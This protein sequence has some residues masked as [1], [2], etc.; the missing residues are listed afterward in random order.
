MHALIHKD[1]GVFT[2]GSYVLHFDPKF[3]AKT[4]AAGS[5]RFRPLVIPALPYNEDRTLCPV[6]A[7]KAY[8]ERVALLRE[9]NH[10]KKLFLSYRPGYV[11][12]I[13]P[14]T[15]SRWI[16]DTIIWS[17]EAAG[18]AEDL[19]RLHKVKAHDVRAMSASLA[20]LHSVALEDIMT[21]GCWSS[22]STFTSHYL[23]DLSVQSKD[24]LRLGPLVAS[25]QVV[26]LTNVAAATYHA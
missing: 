16:R 15:I 1:S 22:H 10:S 21:A 17:Y 3:I 12:D 13:T 2:N 8:M 14:Q 19:L 11:Q 18:K 26:Q 23:R 4:A 20:Y 9:V 24:L 5:S 6:R 7:L 25:R